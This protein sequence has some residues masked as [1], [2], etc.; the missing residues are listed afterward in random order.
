MTEKN[1]QNQEKINKI[2]DPSQLEYHW[3]ENF[4]SP[5]LL[6]GDL[7]SGSLKTLDVISYIKKKCTQYQGN[8]PLELAVEIMNHPII[9]MH[10]AEHH[11]LTPAVLLTVFNNLTKK[12]PNLS[13]KLDE[14][15]EY[16]NNNAPKSCSL[17]AGTCGAAIGSGVFF[18]NFMQDQFVP[19]VLDRLSSYI[20]TESIRQID[21]IGLSRCCKR[22]TYI[23][24]MVAS[25]VM[26]ENLNIEIETSE[27][28]CTFSLRNK[29]CGMEDCPFFNLAN[30][31]G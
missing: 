4:D 29:S 7:S 11:Y 10:G 17:E 13:E 9:R 1:K 31:I 28:K 16:I 20:Q 14:L 26:R 15:E 27:P 18:I 5:E 24:L 22:D 6:G 25:T 23:S 3:D 19:E 12:Y 2:T 8:K 21:E 30:L